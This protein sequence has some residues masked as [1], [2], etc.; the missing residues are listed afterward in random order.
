[1]VYADPLGSESIESQSNSRRE[2]CRD[3]EGDVWREPSQS[4]ADSRRERG[5]MRPRAPSKP[6][7]GCNGAGKLARA[8]AWYKARHEVLS[9]PL[10]LGR[11][12][13][14]P[15]AARGHGRSLWLLAGDRLL[16][17]LRP[18][19]LLRASALGSLLPS[20]CGAPGPQRRPR[21]SA[22]R[23][24]ALVPRSPRRVPRPE[25]LAPLAVRSP[26]DR[27]AFEARACEVIR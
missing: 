23:G 10:P 8:G 11:L 16:D 18:L 17:G 4:S 12:P 19:L 14:R 15:A 13:D 3:S 26:L 5:K 25:S 1:M 9:P 20:G 22:S 6:T 27:P 21:R 24:A 2:R 7:E